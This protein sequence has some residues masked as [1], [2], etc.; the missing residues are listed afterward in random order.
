MA[1]DK[2]FKCPDCGEM[3]LKLANHGC[4]ATIKPTPIPLKRSEPQ[5]APTKPVSK[6]LAK[7]AKA[8]VSLA[9]AP[10][11]GSERIKKWR[12]AHPEDAKRVHR[13]YMKKWR[14]RNE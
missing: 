9:K 13:E 14:V 5:Q 10:L 1:I 12:K 2:R 6:A 4:K 3:V 11:S 8:S 7:V